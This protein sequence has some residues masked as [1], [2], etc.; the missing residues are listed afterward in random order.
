MSVFEISGANKHTIITIQNDPSQRLALK[1]IGHEHYSMYF[2]N[3][4]DLYGDAIATLVAQA[5]AVTLVVVYS[6]LQ[7]LMPVMRFVAQLDHVHLHQDA[8]KHKYL[9]RCKLNEGEELQMGQCSHPLVAPIVL[10]MDSDLF[11]ADPSSVESIFLQQLT[12]FMALL[13][14]GSMM[15]VNNLQEVVESA[16]VAEI[17]SKLEHPDLESDPDSVVQ[18]FTYRDTNTHPSLFIPK[19]WDSWSRIALLAK[20]IY[21]DPLF[22]THNLLTQD[23]E[24]EHLMSLYTEYLAAPQTANSANEPNAA[25]TALLLFAIKTYKPPKSPP[26]SPLPITFQSIID[27]IRH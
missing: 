1:Y 13:H 4:L 22:A 27:S 14:G 10:V 23:S 25:L 24:F 16:T 7:T 3:G 6:S 20:S 21:Y 11:A 19:G 26:T 18:V 8:V 17:I 5:D 15:A 12:R 2:F 9:Q